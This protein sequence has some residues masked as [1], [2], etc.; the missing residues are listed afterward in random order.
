M[1]NLQTL[2]AFIHSRESIIF[3]ESF[4]LNHIKALNRFLY[5]RYKQIPGALFSVRGLMTWNI[6]SSHHA[7]PVCTVPKTLKVTRTTYYYFG[8]NQISLVHRVY[9]KYQQTLPLR[10]SHHVMAL[11]RRHAFMEDTIRYQKHRFL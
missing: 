3:G 7:T 11:N 10:Y 5:G 4:P 9:C 8:L 6:M 2:I 1:T